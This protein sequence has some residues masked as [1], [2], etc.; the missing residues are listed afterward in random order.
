[1]KLRYSQIS[2]NL[3]MSS[4]LKKII[5]IKVTKVDLY[6][7][8]AMKESSSHFIKKKKFRKVV[9]HLKERRKL[10]FKIRELEGEYW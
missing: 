7:L 4:C 10:Y 3:I 1:V 2:S 6:R 5:N 8:Q 9:H